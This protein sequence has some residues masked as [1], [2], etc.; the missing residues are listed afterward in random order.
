MDFSGRHRTALYLGTL[1]SVSAVGAI[2]NSEITNKKRTR[3]HTHIH[4]HTHKD[5]KWT[6]K[7]PLVHSVRVETRR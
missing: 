3:T 2:L 6:E 1:D 5:T 7:R 4:T